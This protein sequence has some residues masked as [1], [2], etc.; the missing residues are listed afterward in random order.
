MSLSSIVNVTI[1]QASVGLAQAG[2]G[3]P[4]IVS[5]TATF[6]QRVRIYEE[7]TDVAA[8]FP[9]TT[10]PEYLASQA[11]FAQTPHPEEIMI[12]RSA[13]PPTQAY[14]L[15]ILSVSA[16]S[17]YTLNVQGKGVTP[18]AVTY[19]T[20]SGDLTMT[21]FS[22]STNLWACTAHGMST[23]DGPYRLSTSG[24]LPTG[25]A[26]DTNYWVIASDANDFK[27]ASSKAN[28]IALTAVTASSNGT[29]PFT[30]RRVQ[31]DVICAQLVQGL[32]AVVGANYVAAQVTGAGETDTV[33]IT[34][35]SPGGWF[36]VENTS[37]V[38]MTLKQN[39]S[40]AGIATSLT[41]I[42]LANSDWY[43]LYTMYNSDAV[44]AAAAAWVETQQ[45]IYLA[46]CCDTACLNNAVTTGDALDALHTSL[47]TRTSGWYHQ[48]PASFIGAA[49]EGACLPLPPGSET[50]MFKPLVNVAP[51]A[52]TPTQAANLAAKK[53][54]TYTYLASGVP[55]TSNGFTADGRYIDSRRGLDSFVNDLQV[56]IF[57][58]LSQLKKVPFTN[59]GVAIIENVMR[60]AVERAIAAG[61]FSDDP[62]D[63]P[64]YS[65][66]LVA[67][68]SDTDKAGRLLPDMDFTATQ[69]GAVQATQVNGNVAL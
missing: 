9:D 33:T 20:P 8:D 53:A 66:P 25:F 35:N 47:Y 11:I 22:D 24:V 37:S 13:L 51:I 56:S 62:A 34:A 68:I 40:D 52:M 12:G 64:T 6:S 17:P 44:I 55:M 50:W 5:E 21:S 49:V 67:D 63:A 39:H 19:T 61:I 45:K 69:A 26:V 58:A 10:S 48:S 38:E 29:A 31:N 46:D 15:A 7:L 1:T 36:S 57:N 60:G 54:N 3:I 65:V 43:A 23:G 41:A 18:T 2:F 16:L 30:L 28:A 32:N 59:K 14:L 42:A 4:L 27:L